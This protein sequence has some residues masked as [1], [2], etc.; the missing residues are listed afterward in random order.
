MDVPYVT[1]AGADAT[2]VLGDEELVTTGVAAKVLGTSR[3][4]VVDLCD[5][6]DLPFRTVGKHRRVS[7]SDLEALSARTNRL[8]RDQLRSLWLSQAVAGKLVRDPE[9]V[10]SQARRALAHLRTVHRRGQAARWLAEWEVILGGPVERVLETLTSPTPRARDLRQNS[11][12]AGVLTEK[13]RAQVL[14]SFQRTRV[15]SRR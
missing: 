8:T 14:Q 1:N 13:E 9:G 2:D 3:Q 12:F 7:R 6:G 11:P 15:A 4:H 5:R 10:L